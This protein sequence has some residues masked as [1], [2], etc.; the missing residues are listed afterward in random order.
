MSLDRS[1]FIDQSQSHNCFMR[2]PTFYKL[3]SYHF[4]G[5]KNNAKTGMYYFRQPAAKNPINFALLGGGIEIKNSTY[6]GEDN[7]VE[8]L[9]CGS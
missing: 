4:H 3:S 9:M 5:W 7:D 1:P 2:N 6:K 8:C